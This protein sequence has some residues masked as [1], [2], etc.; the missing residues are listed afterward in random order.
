M[1]IYTTTWFTNYKTLLGNASSTLLYIQ[2]SIS[3]IILC[4]SSRLPSSM[5]ELEK[6]YGNINAGKIKLFLHLK[7]AGYMVLTAV[8]L[9]RVVITVKNTI[10]MVRVANTL[11]LTGTFELRRSAINY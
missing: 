4:T 9:I 10:T 11:I 1:P 6:I 5:F 3:L 7:H 2:Y 8:F